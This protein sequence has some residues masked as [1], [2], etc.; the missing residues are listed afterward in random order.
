MIVHSSG[1]VGRAYLDVDLEVLRRKADPIRRLDDFK[2]LNRYSPWFALI[3]LLL[4]FSMAGVPPLVGFYANGEFC[5][6]RLYGYTGVLTLF[7]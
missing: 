2:G 6:D 5:Y 3:M 1:L 7:C 4:M